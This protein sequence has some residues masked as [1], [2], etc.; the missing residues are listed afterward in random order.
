MIF[1]EGKLPPEFGSQN[2]GSMKVREKAVL[3]TLMG[4]LTLEIHGKDLFEKLKDSILVSYDI[5]PIIAS[6]TEATVGVVVNRWD[7]MAEFLI[8]TSALD[9][10]EAYHT[11]IPQKG[12]NLLFTDGMKA[13]RRSQIAGLM[14][15]CLEDVA[16]NVSN[17]FGEKW[18]A[19][20][21][22]RPEKGTFGDVEQF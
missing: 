17:L 22:I 7:L 11:K 10:L 18:P 3:H 12:K 5:T 16:P 15:I 13:H 1:K 9:A 19:L 20:S 4:G 21:S 8:D 6:A 14:K 2:Y